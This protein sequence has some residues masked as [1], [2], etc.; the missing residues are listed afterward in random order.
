M[1]TVLIVDDEKNIR[2]TLARG[3]CASRLPDRKEATNGIE[4]LK[5]SR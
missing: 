5:D 2:A 1:P 4:A 3:S